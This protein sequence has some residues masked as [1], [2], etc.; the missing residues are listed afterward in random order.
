MET[1][2]VHVQKVGQSS[3]MLVGVWASDQAFVGAAT[4]VQGMSSLRKAALRDCVLETVPR[5]LSGLS[6]LT[7]LDLTEN[8]FKGPREGGLWWPTALTM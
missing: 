6:A 8:C 5:A 2:A 4:R 3:C 1:P 7:S